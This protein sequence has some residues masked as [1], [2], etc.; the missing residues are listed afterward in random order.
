[1]KFDK[2]LKTLNK[3][4]ETILSSTYPLE[5]FQLNS[6]LSTVKGRVF[7][8]AVALLSNNFDEDIENALSETAKVAQKRFLLKQKD[9]KRAEK[10]LNKYQKFIAQFVSSQADVSEKAGIENTR[11]TKVLNLTADDFYAYEVFSIAKSQGITP[12][13][14]FEQLYKENT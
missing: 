9:K 4:F 6:D 2:F 1:M 5:S 7:Y 8:K 14:A 13:S 11:F 10:T 3:E 12:K